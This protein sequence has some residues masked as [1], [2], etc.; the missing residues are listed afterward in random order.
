[1]Y[2]LNGAVDTEGRPSYYI[3]LVQGI[4]STVQ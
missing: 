4:A 1:V 3:K 2:A